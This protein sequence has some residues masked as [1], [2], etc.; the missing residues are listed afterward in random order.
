MESNLQLFKK[1]LAEIDRYQ[2]QMRIFSD[3]LH[4]AAL[5]QH[6]SG[7][8]L[9]FLPKDENYEEKEA[10]YML[11]IKRYKPE[12][13]DHFARLMS[14]TQMALHSWGGDFLGCVYMELQGDGTKQAAGQFFTPFEISYMMAMMTLGDIAEA[15]TAKG[16]TTLSEPASGGGGMLIAVAKYCHEQQID[17]QRVFFQAIDVNQNCFFMTYIQTAMLGMPGYV[18]QGNTLSGEQQTAWATPALQLT[19]W[20]YPSFFAEAATILPKV[21]QQTPTIT[22]AGQLV[23]F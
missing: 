12:Q 18:I 8:N 2:D 13:L 4:I 1:E 21:A 16:Y 22:K 6:Q 5:V 20:H 9:G 7:Y 11:A 17:R 3:F 23:L 14:I 10:A 15:I 19:Q